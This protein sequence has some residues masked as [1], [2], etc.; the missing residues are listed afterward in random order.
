MGCYAAL[1]AVR[2]AS[3][4]VAASGQ[5]ALVVSVELCSLHLQPATSRQDAVSQALFG[6]GAAAAVIAPGAPGA[7]GPTSGALASGSV[8][9]PGGAPGPAGLEIVAARTTTLPGSEDRMGW[10]IG[11]DGFHMSLSPRVPALVDRGLGALVEQL[12][13]PHGLVPDDVA[14][15][16][17]HPGG[18]EILDRVQRRLQH[19][20]QSAQQRRV[21][22]GVELDLDPATAVGDVILDCL[23][24]DPPQLVWRADDGSGGVVALLERLPV[25]SLVRRE[26]RWHGHAMSSG[27]LGQR[28]RAQRA[29]QVQVKVGLWQTPE[30]P[31][32]TAS[33]RRVRRDRAHR[34]II[35]AFSL[36]PPRPG[37]DSGWDCCVRRDR[38]C[39]AKLR[40]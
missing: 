29:G 33:G 19:G 25:V 16:A 27:Q 18:P 4:L 1:P 34:V 24:N 12:L 40:A 10:L 2:T 30:V 7:G 6:D 3:A 31:G 22:G 36:N 26:G 13:A 38:V 32:P 9:L 28:L 39:A 14:H 5:R 35:V 21:G 20:L 17:V 8:A 15:W 11:D 37:V 23:C